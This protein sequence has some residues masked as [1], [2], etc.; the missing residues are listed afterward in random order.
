MPDQNSCNRFS[1]PERRVH[2]NHFVREILLR[3]RAR[4]RREDLVLG[5][6]REAFVEPRRQRQ[7]LHQAVRQFV[8]DHRLHGAVLQAFPHDEMPIAGI[9]EH[10]AGHREL[11][12]A[13]N[14]S[15]RN[16]S[17]RPGC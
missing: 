9:D 10:A 8:R 12:G 4:Q 15:R 17:N 11:T 2:G 6:H 3:A 14:S 1:V 13:G 7:M 5:V 16:R